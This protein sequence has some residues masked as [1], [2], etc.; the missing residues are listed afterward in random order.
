MVQQMHSSGAIGISREVR[1]RL[2]Q[3]LKDCTLSPE[4]QRILRGI[5]MAEPVADLTAAD[6]K[7]ME[8][9]IER[10]INDGIN[11][12]QRVAYW[13]GAGDMFRWLTGKGNK[14]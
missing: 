9:T 8:A 10:N 12:N 7:E 6:L 1:D 2:I 4:A 14:L 11:L 13:E 5:L 3:A